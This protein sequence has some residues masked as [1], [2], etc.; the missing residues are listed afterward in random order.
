[1]AEADWFFWWI[2]ERQFGIPITLRSGRKVL[3]N[4]INPERVKPR[5]P[6]PDELEALGCGRENAN[7]TKS[8]AAVVKSG[9]QWFGSLLTSEP[10]LCGDCEAILP[11]TPSGVRSRRTVCRRCENA[12]FYAAH[13][14]RNRER[15]RNQWRTSKQ[16]Q[17]AK[18]RLPSHPRGA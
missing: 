8:I 9:A 18:K 16:K 17:R 10:A 14:Q 6:T 13:A 2:C 4:R 15:L 7:H 12:A 5:G 11:Q 1:K 3:P